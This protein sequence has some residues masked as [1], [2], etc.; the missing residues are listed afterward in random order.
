MF[1]SPVKVIGGAVVT[2]VESSAINTPP[3]VIS[4]DT[5]IFPV[6]SSASVGLVVLIPTKLLAEIVFIKFVFN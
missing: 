2:L 5:N 3:I 6:T 4:D 1:V